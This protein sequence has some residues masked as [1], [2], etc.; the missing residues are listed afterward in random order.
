MYEQLNKIVLTLSHTLKH[1]Q[2][3]VIQKIQ[4]FNSQLYLYI[5]L[6]CI[7][8]FSYI[9]EIRPVKCY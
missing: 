9:I 3:A 4:K 6:I 2:E 8:Y 1:R 7:L 5:F